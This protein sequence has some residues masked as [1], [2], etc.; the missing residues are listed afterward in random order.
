MELA[1]RVK[2]VLLRSP[3]P[4]EL[5]PTEK[6]SGV[7]SNSGIV[8]I[9]DELATNVPI[10]VSK[11]IIEQ[12]KKMVII[13]KLPTTTPEDPKRFFTVSA[14][15]KSLSFIGNNASD[16]YIRLEGEEIG[17]RE[18]IERSLFEMFKNPSTM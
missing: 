2:P 3:E 8:G 4:R 15:E 11:E 5:Q 1:E 7:M 17:N 13:V 12:G 14:T 16:N 18:A 10:K 6:L 9:I